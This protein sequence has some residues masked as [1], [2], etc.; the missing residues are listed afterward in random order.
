MNKN[1]KILLIIVIVFFILLTLI[2]SVISTSGKVVD[3][4]T[5]E[6]LNEA[7]VLIDVNK[8]SGNFTGTK[9]PHE[10]FLKTFDLITNKNGRYSS[11]LEIR[12]H[13]PIMVYYSKEYSCYKFGYY[14]DRRSDDYLKGDLKLLKI[15]HYLDLVTRY[16]WEYT[17]QTKK[18][19]YKSNNTNSIKRVTESKYYKIMF[20]KVNSMYI[21]PLDKEGVFFRK[22]GSEFTKIYN[23]DNRKYF[24]AY[25]NK[26]KE[27]IKISFQGRLLKGRSRKFVY[28]DMEGFKKG[29]FNWRNLNLNKKIHDICGN[30]SNYFIINKNKE[31]LYHRGNS[32]NEYKY[33]SN[34][35]RKSNYL[36][37][38]TWKDLPGKKIDD[39]LNTSRFFF[40]IND[41]DFNFTYTYFITKTN[42]FWHV[43]K[44]CRPDNIKNNKRIELIGS[45]NIKDDILH[46]SINN[47]YLYTVL[48]NNG[49]KAYRIIKSRSENRKKRTYIKER[50]LFYQNTKHILFNKNIIDIIAGY[51]VYIVTGD[52]VIYGFNYKGWPDRL[53][54]LT[55]KYNDGSWAKKM[56]VEFGS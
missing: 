4:E 45:L 3:A 54:M 41:A 52:E 11:P 27:W 32:S 1:R 12:L 40:L 47:N 13:M 7:I 16:P 44:F 2:I 53:I 18:E 30:K 26:N 43:Y 29:C 56:K 35:S 38:Y 49:I 5:G 33:Y 37:N 21:K 50:P 23:Y 20:D 34:I 28:N 42:K 36:K 10:E 46:V 19:Y 39:T 48:K 22:K 14:N 24:M 8:E 31:I 6:P 55:D 15:N 51:K 9:G 25:D 17:S